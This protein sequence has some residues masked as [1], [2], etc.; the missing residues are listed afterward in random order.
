MRDPV[1]VVLADD[2]ALLRE[3]LARVLTEAGIKVAAQT[4]TARDLLKAVDELEPDVAVVDIRMPPTHTDEGLAAAE[5]IRQ[6]F[7]H[8]GVLLLSQCRGRVRPQA[9]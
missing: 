5:E 3:G 2:A 6:R 4:G 8:V 1:R 7:P 9:S